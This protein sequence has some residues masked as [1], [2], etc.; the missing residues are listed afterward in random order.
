[1]KKTFVVTGGNSGLGCQCAKNI[2]ME[3]ADN[4]VVIASRNMERSE[5]AAAN[6][7]GETGNPHIYAMPLD[8]ASQAS[9]R[10]F[11]ETFASRDLPPLYGLVCN[12]ISGS[13]PS[14]PEYTEDG[15]EMTFATGHL[16]HFLLANLLLKNMQ[17]G[18]RIVF[19]SSDQH[20]PPRMIATISYT[21]ALDIA[22]SRCNKHAV[23]YSLTK[24]CN[25]YCAYE[26]AERAVN[27]ISV[28]AFNPGF[29]ADTGLGG[30]AKSVGEKIIKRLA[31]LLARLMGKYSTAQ[32][33][34]KLLAEMMTGPRY[35]GVTGKYFDRGREARSSELSYSKANAVNLWERSME[36]TKNAHGPQKE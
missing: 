35:E 12:A 21:D 28:N 8:L 29:M 33:S 17:G 18:G 6:I 22:R 32:I 14:K 10:D 20:D 5:R 1:M 34:G 26:M 16:G 27:N 3:S 2:A 36:L 13:G 31:P 7:A 4:H 15:F 24:L 9:V 19:V 11:A 30:G 25:L 23:R